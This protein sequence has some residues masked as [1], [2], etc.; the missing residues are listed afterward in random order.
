M[1]V[2]TIITSGCYGDASFKPWH[3]GVFFVNNFVFFGF[4]S[5]NIYYFIS[6]DKVPVYSE[7]ALNT[8]KNVI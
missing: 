1:I 4:P 8:K 7:F 3:W 5:L 2:Q 6:R